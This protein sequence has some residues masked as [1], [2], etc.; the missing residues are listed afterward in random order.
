MDSTV[1]KLASEAAEGRAN[2][3]NKDQNGACYLKLSLN[4]ATLHLATARPN[5]PY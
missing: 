5:A 2:V 4:T 1:Q 3:T